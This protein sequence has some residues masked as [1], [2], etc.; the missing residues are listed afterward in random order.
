MDKL[1]YIICCLILSLV[2]GGTWGGFLAWI[3]PAWA[4]PV[5]LVLF[6]LCFV[7]LMNAGKEEEEFPEHN[8]RFNDV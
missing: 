2:L 7:V 5:G 8:R 4:L 3:Y 6:V 1:I